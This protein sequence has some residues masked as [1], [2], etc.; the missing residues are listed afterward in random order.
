[1]LAAGPSRAACGPFAGLLCDDVGMADVHQAAYK[2]ENLSVTLLGS[3]SG[4]S[5]MPQL[6]C[7]ERTFAQ[8]PACRGPVYPWR[9]CPE[10]GM[11]LTSGALPMDH[12]IVPKASRSL[13]EGLFLNR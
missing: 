2:A 12:F 7:S 8:P 11:S 10:A 1:M 6:A 5:C 9:A 4:K 13:S 3:L